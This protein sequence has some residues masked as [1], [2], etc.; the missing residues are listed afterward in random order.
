M[1]YNFY[2]Q[3]CTS[4]MEDSSNK[5]F[6]RKFIINQYNKKIIYNEDYIY[7][8]KNINKLNKIITKNDYNFDLYDSS[9]LDNIPYPLI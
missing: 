6:V 1:S 4:P 8:L 7:S 9:T 2:Y 5:Y 3:I